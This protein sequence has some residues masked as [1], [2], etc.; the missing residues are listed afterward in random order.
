MNSL[1]VLKGSRARPTARVS[2]PSYDQEEHP[3]ADELTRR[4]RAGRN[5]TSKATE[6]AARVLF[7]R[8]RGASYSVIPDVVFYAEILCRECP[9]R[10]RSRVKTSPAINSPSK[11]ISPD[12]RIHDIIIIGVKISPSRNSTS[13]VKNK[14]NDENLPLLGTNLISVP[15]PLYKYKAVR[16]VEFLDDDAARSH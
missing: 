1:R 9:R 10:R 13:M 12:V 4:R 5:Y 14:L 2:F 6:D 3:N 7:A 8:I 16:F 11:H 15:F